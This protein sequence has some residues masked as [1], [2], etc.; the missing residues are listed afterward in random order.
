MK[1][2]L[3]A[4]LLLPALAYSQPQVCAVTGTFYGFDASLADSIDVTVVRVYDSSGVLLYSKPI[5]YRTGGAMSGSLRG[6]V[7]FNI[8]RNS[9][10]YI[11]ARAMNW[12][13]YGPTGKGVVIPNV[14]SG[15]LATFVAADSV[16]SSHLVI[17]PTLTLTD[18]TTGLSVVTDTIRLGAGLKLIA[19]TNGGGNPTIIG[20]A[21]GGGGSND[22][23]KILYDRIE[24]KAARDS[25][26]SK[27]DTSKLHAQQF[28]VINDKL[29]G[30]SKADSNA[31]DHG[32]L[33]TKIDS[34]RATVISNLEAKD[35]L[36]SDLIA[37]LQEADSTITKISLALD[38]AFTLGARSVSS[39]GRMFVASDSITSTDI[40]WATGNF[41][42]TTLSGSITFTFSNPLPGQTIFVR[43]TQGAGAYTVAWPATVRWVTTAYTMTAVANKIGTYSFVYD[44][45]RY[46]GNYA[47]E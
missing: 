4:L 35:K 44:G 2:I 1:K 13:I 8:V 31:T 41:F 27:A 14:A 24:S 16:P 5:K 15:D 38:S 46:I 22:S 39:T 18:S 19:A 37:G 20:T 23:V 34:A 47:G 29:A 43:L 21:T 7:Q 45:I 6:V 9:V 32:R 42:Y 12:D 28:A 30:L 11:S 36:L 17:F 26:L 40:N 3:F 33:E 25:V 10:A